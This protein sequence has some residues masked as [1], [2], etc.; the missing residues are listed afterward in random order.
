MESF[1]IIWSTIAGGY[2]KFAD[3]RES[4]RLVVVHNL[5]PISSGDNVTVLSQSLWPHKLY[6]VH[7]MNSRTCPHDH[8]QNF[9]WTSESLVVEGIL[10]KIIFLRKLE[11]L[12]YRSL[13]YGLHVHQNH[14]FCNNCYT[15]VTLSS[16]H[17][18]YLIATNH[19]GFSWSIYSID[20]FSWTEIA[21]ILYFF[22]GR[23]IMIMAT[24]FVNFGIAMSMFNTEIKARIFGN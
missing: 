20:V 18:R 6:E 9:Y 10:Q 2:S 1:G 16:C 17:K 15:C 4:L 19:V 22:W 14:F 8:N 11:H 5:W 12:N 23:I 21:Q 13:N 3:E 7:N 24:C